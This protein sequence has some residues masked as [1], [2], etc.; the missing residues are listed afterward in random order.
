MRSILYKN[1]TSPYATK[2]ALFTDSVSGWKDFLTDIGIGQDFNKKD[3]RVIPGAELLNKLKP[4]LYDPDLIFYLEYE[5]EK[6]ISEL[7]TLG[8]TF[9]NLVPR[10]SSSYIISDTFS[11]TQILD[12]IPSTA[13]DAGRESSNVA[14][15]RSQLTNANAAWNSLTLLRSYDFGS[16]TVTDDAQELWPGTLVEESINSVKDKLKDY[17]GLDSLPDPFYTWQQEDQSGTFE[18]KAAAVIQARDIAVDSTQIGQ[19]RDTLSL[20][21]DALLSTYTPAEAYENETFRAAVENTANF[22]AQYCTYLETFLRN[23]SETAYKVK[24][25][26]VVRFYP[27][28][29]HLSDP[30]P[31]VE[32]V[33]LSENSFV[34][35]AHPQNNLVVTFQNNIAL[36]T[37]DTQWRELYNRIFKVIVRNGNPKCKAR[38]GRYV[39]DNCYISVVPDL[40]ITVNSAPVFTFALISEEWDSS[41][42]QPVN[43]VG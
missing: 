1:N 23:S 11:S 2:S 37:P 25:G 24:P 36:D 26:A 33:Q 9:D 4:M 43:Y 16:N 3:L 7:K 39:L 18:T 14:Y 8:M 13:G 6:V 28:A 30:I 10:Q 41:K 42:L 15:I 19:E 40:S 21:Q 27:A 32:T 34:Q 12:N 29:V 17:K 31:Q 5:N 35:V 20:E 22:I 38:I